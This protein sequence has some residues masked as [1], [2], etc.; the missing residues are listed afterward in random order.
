MLSCISGC[1]GLAELT[2]CSWIECIC[3]CSTVF[4]SLRISGLTSHSIGRQEEDKKCSCL[5]ASWLMGV[6]FFFPGERKKLQEPSMLAAVLYHCIGS[7]QTYPANY[8][9]NGRSWR[10]TCC[11]RRTGKA[12]Q[13]SAQRLTK[14]VRRPPPEWP[15]C[16]LWPS[17]LQPSATAPPPQFL[18]ST[19]WQPVQQ[20]VATLPR[21]SNGEVPHSI[22]KP[23]PAES[24]TVA[25]MRTACL[26]KKNVTTQHQGSQ[27]CSHTSPGA[28]QQASCHASRGVARSL[29]HSHWEAGC[30]YGD[31]RTPATTPYK[32]ARYE[33]DRCLYP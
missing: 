30:I 3:Y 22:I 18:K 5:P 2:I 13:G 20:L 6:F 25:Q 23:E 31:I 29:A 4:T 33:G 17:H 14:S 12:A 32:V 21:F 1:F 10:G 19:R 15:R 27:P 8:L 28:P 24:W 9:E 26:G 11:M 7:P 16:T